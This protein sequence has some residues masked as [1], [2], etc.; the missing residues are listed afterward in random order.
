MKQRE[1]QKSVGVDGAPLK[2]S[3][4]LETGAA[5]RLP[6]ENAGLRKVA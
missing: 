5:A 3:D 6:C 2:K 1:V 4:K